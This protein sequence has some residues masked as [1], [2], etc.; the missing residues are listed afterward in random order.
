MS[1]QTMLDF[2]NVSPAVV[3]DQCGAS[4][5]PAD[6]E[7]PFC[8]CPTS[9]SILSS[10]KLRMGHGVGIYTMEIGKLQS[11]VFIFL[12]RARCSAFISQMCDP[13]LLSFSFIPPIFPSLP[14]SFHRCLF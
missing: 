10:W 8:H 12:Q 14:P 11:R 9:H 13:R 1:F 3:T 4:L 6:S 2:L 7:P 5:A